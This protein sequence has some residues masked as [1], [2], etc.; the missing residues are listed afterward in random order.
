MSE[1]KPNPQIHSFFY[2]AAF[3][4]DGESIGMEKIEIDSLS[5]K[6]TE[7]CAKYLERHGDN[8]DTPWDENL[9]FIRTRLTSASGTALITFSSNEKPAASIFLARG[10]SQATELSVLKMFINSLRNTD[11]V[12]ASARSI[13]PFEEMF[14][15]E[16]RPL[17]VV[18]PWADPDI[19]DN[20]NKIVRELSMHLAAAYFTKK[21][22]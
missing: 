6:W 4:I 3:N 22:E 9:S 13:E 19:T 14:S 21:I 10:I 2:V 11:L 15:I 17:M 16:D 18:V 1:N 7:N 12:R 8:F 20:E 5:S